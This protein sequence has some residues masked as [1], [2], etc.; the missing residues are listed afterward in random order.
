MSNSNTLLSDKMQTLDNRITNISE[1]MNSIKTSILT[2]KVWV[3][4]LTWIAGIIG[5]ILAGIATGFFQ[6]I[7][8]IFAK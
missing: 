3:K 2:A 8:N 1:D 4:V 6:N 5:A 7:I